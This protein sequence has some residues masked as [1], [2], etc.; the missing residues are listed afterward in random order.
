MQQIRSIYLI[1]FLLYCF[2]PTNAGKKIEAVNGV[3]DL[4]DYNFEKS[5]PLNLSGD[6][7][8]FWNQLIVNDIPDSQSG[9]F[10]VTV[11][12]S[13]NI[14][15]RR[16]IPV[17]N[18]GYATYHLKILLPA[19]I[20]ELGFKAYDIHSSSAF[21][22]NGKQIL[23]VGMPATNRF[24]TVIGVR[25]PVFE[26]PVENSELDLRIQVAN[27]EHRS[28][29]IKGGITIGLPD[30]II[31]ISDRNQK[32][33]FFFMGAFFIIGIYFLSLY[34]IRFEQYR[35]YF[36][37]ICLLM[38]FRIF[39]LEEVEILDSLN[40][41]SVGIY[42]LKYLSIYLIIPF[43]I[44]MIKSLFSIEFRKLSFN[45]LLWISLGFILVVLFT[46]LSIFSYTLILYQ[47]Y[48]VAVAIKLLS[49][50]ILAWKRGRNYAPMFT[51]GMTVIII[52]IVN[53]LLYATD[54]V[55]T[56]YI[57]H[58]TM[59]I[60]L[61]IYAHIFAAKSLH[62]IIRAEALSKEI[63][64]VNTNLEAIVEERTS[65]LKENSRRLEKQQRELETM[66]RNLSSA[67][68]SRN[69]T[70]S[71]IGHDIRGPI[72]YI[73]Q[74]LDLLN[75]QEKL[76]KK[77]NTELT[78]LLANTAHKTYDLLEN[79][80]LWG[81][82]QVGS[83]QPKPVKINLQEIINECIEVVDLGIRE[84]ELSVKSSVEPGSE[85]FADRDQILI[86]LRNLLTNAIKFTPVGGSVVISTSRNR[87][88]KECIVKVKDSGIGIPVKLQD[89]IFD[90]DEN[91]TSDGT[92]HEKGSGIGLKLCKEITEANGGWIRFKSKSGKGSEFEIGI[93]A[94]SS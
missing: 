70:F 7:I 89:R 57:A 60:F 86:V 10:I 90:P 75:E 24:Q 36:S 56:G 47:V 93:P 33:S 35:L 85:M 94:Y 15:K 69:R 49:V 61:L 4:R 64:L 72:G 40:I 76:K 54:I 21:Y 2:Q 5:G 17:K 9:K 88:G 53:D 48:F 32:L 83:L 52:G 20:K 28:G 42:R 26:I 65:E 38:V 84:K 31:Q 34:L 58:F 91:F 1:I 77:E 16:G 6:W 50:L 67:I 37:M 12:K 73:R 29:G 11:P 8:I 80:M 74:G 18:K 22:I 81:R 13:W 43:F 14:Y 3:I 62:L 66:N 68:M 71:I 27:F 25:D 30:Q 39:V 92:N 45:L 44:L 87:S 41:S 78:N 63:Q 55:E 19:G 46:P 82:S 23:R 79:L 51:I 59:F